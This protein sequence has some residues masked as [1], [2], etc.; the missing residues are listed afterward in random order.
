MSD[1]EGAVRAPEP[2]TTSTP[3]PAPD[4]AETTPAEAPAA[5]ATTAVA[6]AERP[7]A[8]PTAES[9]AELTAESAAAEQ[10]ADAGTST[11]GAALAFLK[12]HA[13]TLVLAVLL[14]AA[15]VWGALGLVSVNDWKARAAAT[16]SDL[17]SVE[18]T[19]AEARATI[20]DLEIARDRAESTATACVGAIDDADAMLE[21]SAEIDEKTVVYLEGLTDLMS[22]VAAGDVAGAETIGAEVDALGVQLEDLS[23]RIEGHI[24]DYED[25][26]KGCH[27][28][29]VQDA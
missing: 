19:L 6:T 1:D 9:T 26:A 16:A 15:I 4:P 21:V 8:E 13:V 25:T 28:D 17:A 3:E 12:T 29:D 7:A 18:Q 22:A 14:V 11:P 23:E 2:S 5:T 10:P 20:D 24:D 27:V